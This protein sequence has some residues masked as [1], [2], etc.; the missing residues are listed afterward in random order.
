MLAISIRIFSIFQ[1]SNNVNFCLKYLSF[2]HLTNVLRQ[3]FQ[4]SQFD[5]VSHFNFHHLQTLLKS[6]LSVQ[7]V[8][9]PKILLDSFLTK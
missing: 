4:P 9:F 6:Y 7:I 3:Y 2:L 5:L 1:G 8:Q